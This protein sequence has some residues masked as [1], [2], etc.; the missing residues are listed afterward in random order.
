[1]SIIPK[2]EGGEN[3]DPTYSDELVE[4]LKH[5]L[6]QGDFRAGELLAQVIEDELYGKWSTFSEFV[7]GELRISER[8]AYRLIAAFQIA[9]QLKEHGCKLPVNERQ[10]RPLST[11]KPD[12]LV[13]RPK[14]DPY[15]P[16]RVTA[17]KRACDLKQGTLPTYVDVQREVHRIVQAEMAALAGYQGDSE[18][19]W[20][21]HKNLRRMQAALNRATVILADGDLE[22]FLIGA[23]GPGSDK[24]DIRRLKK[25]REMVLNM[26]VQLGDHLKKLLGKQEEVEEP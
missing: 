16:A 20:R 19:Y 21:Y 18:A 1:M 9:V 3:A 4:E 15:E 23:T 25:I 8:T 24:K 26:G 2:P 17:W 6:R 7:A 12:D 11:F 5:A 14:G 10:V 13:L 22:S